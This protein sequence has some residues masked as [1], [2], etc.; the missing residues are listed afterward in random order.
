MRSFYCSLNSNV[1]YN[2]WIEMKQMTVHGFMSLMY[3]GSG[4]MVMVSAAKK[5]FITAVR[6]TDP[7]ERFYI[8]PLHHQDI[9]KHPQLSRVMTREKVNPLAT[10]ASTGTFRI[11]LKPPESSIYITRSGRFWFESRLLEAETSL[12]PFVAGED[13]E[14]YLDTFNKSKKRF[15]EDIRFETLLRLVPDD[16]TYWFRTESVAWS[17]DELVANFKNRFTP[18]YQK[19]LAATINQRMQTDEPLKP[20]VERKIDAYLATGMKWNSVLSLLRS[21]DIESDEI[22]GLIKIWAP[23]DRSEL[24]IK[25]Q[26]FD[27]I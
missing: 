2:L 21:K 5:L 24:L 14:K 11:T 18:I 26:R 3:G 27:E 6:F 10:N 19:T 15:C 12:K 1:I 8:I 7:D 17:F 13:P 4:G 23:K 9:G 25:A 20:F 16:H 22:K